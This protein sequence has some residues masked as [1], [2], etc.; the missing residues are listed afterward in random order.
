M[1]GLY[2]GALP[3][4]AGMF[5]LFGFG[6]FLVFACLRPA[7]GADGLDAGRVG[8]MAVP[9][10]ASVLLGAVA[11]WF[12]V[13]GWDFSPLGGPWPAGFLFAAI[14]GIPLLCGACYAA[15]MGEGVRGFAHARRTRRT[16]VGFLIAGTLLGLGGFILCTQMASPAALPV[17][18][19]AMTQ[20]TMAI[21]ALTAAA[22]FSILALRSEDTGYY[23][24]IAFVAALLGS[25]CALMVLF[26]A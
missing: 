14:A 11:A 13:Q 9:P 5:L 6:A 21:F 16:I 7:M 2:A 1:D 3:A 25:L 19:A 17:L 18:D 23:S 24:T 20:M 26:A 12:G 22:V 15:M 8:A 10:G 4:L